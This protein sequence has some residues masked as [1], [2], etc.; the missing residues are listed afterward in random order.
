M[1][2]M[3]LTD[4]RIKKKQNELMLH[5]RL[6][7]VPNPWLV[8]HKMVGYFLSLQ[9]WADQTSLKIVWWW[10]LAVMDLTFKRTGTFC[11]ASQRPVLPHNVWLPSWRTD[12]GSLILNEK[13]EKP[14][15]VRPSSF[16]YKSI[17]HVNEIILDPPDQSNIWI[18]LGELR[19]EAENCPESP[20]LT[21]DSQN[22][23]VKMVVVL[24]HWALE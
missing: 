19:Q 5:I 18:P 7:I 6:K 13:G 3:I 1:V 15:W 12:G 14:C 20:F 10:L 2:S 22:Q 23:K 21:S 11:P 17:K 8:F 16:P 24:S 4:R 9:I